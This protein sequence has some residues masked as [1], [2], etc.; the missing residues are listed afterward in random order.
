[1]ESGG[2]RF[3]SRSVRAEELRGRCD[4]KRPEEGLGA[5]I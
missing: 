1:M 4:D 5:Y 2:E 3:Y